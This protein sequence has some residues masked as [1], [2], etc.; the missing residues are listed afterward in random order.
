MK[1]SRAKTLSSGKSSPSCHHQEGYEQIQK[2]NKAMGNVAKKRAMW[3]ATTGDLARPLLKGHTPHL[4]NSFMD[5]PPS[6]PPNAM[7]RRLAGYTQAGT[8]FG[9]C[10][11]KPGTLASAELHFAA[12]SLARDGQ[13]ETSQAFVEAEAGKDILKRSLQSIRLHVMLTVWEIEEAGRHAELLR[14]LQH[15]NIEGHAD[16]S[17]EA[18]WFERFLS[19]RSLAEVKDDF[20]F[21]RTVYPNDLTLLATADEQL[22]QLECHAEERGLILS[23][24][25]LAQELKALIVEGGEESEAD[26]DDSLCSSNAESAHC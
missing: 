15:S 8:K 13:C 20:D 24:E 17:N 2:V 22:N 23:K 14:E 21:N 26:S 25:E 3:R 5:P 11:V 7:A 4:M 18:I 1:H 16:A 9:P 19:D 10:V 6:Y 12:K